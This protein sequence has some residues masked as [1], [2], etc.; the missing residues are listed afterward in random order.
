MCDTDALD[1]GKKE[2]GV[3]EP[4]IHKHDSNALIIQ[5]TA[6][7]YRNNNFNEAKPSNSCASEKMHKNKKGYVGSYHHELII[8]L[9]PSFNWI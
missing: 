4:Q 5:L 2:S 6:S 7:E 9:Q 8:M 1:E 3:V